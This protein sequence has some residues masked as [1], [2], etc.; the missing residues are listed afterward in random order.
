MRIEALAGRVFLAL[1]AVV[2]T[3]VLIEVASRRLVPT[4]PG[5][6]QSLDLGTPREPK[7]YV[8]F[9]TDENGPYVNRLGYP[10]PVPALPKPAGEYRIFML[11]GS[12]VFAGNPPLAVQIERELRT[13]GLDA[14]RVYNFGVVSSV[15]GMELARIVFE[16]GGYE[17]DLVLLYDGGNDVVVPFLWDPRPGY[18]FNFLLYESNPLMQDADR[19]PTALLLG[20]GSNLL[21]RTFR[22]FFTER[23][24]G[25]GRLRAEA[26]WQTEPWRDA[27][28][29]TYVD[30]LVKGARASRGFG[31]KFMGFLQPLL[32][33]KATL[34]E[35]EVT[36]RDVLDHEHPGLREHCV[37]MRPKMQAAMRAAP[38]DVRDDFVDMSGVYDAVPGRT[39]VDFIHPIQETTP[40]LVHVIARAILDR[41]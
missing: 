20:F 19:Y 9:G 23:L 10:G 5:L 1:V 17:P 13:S 35:H 41:R 3:L 39:F 12:T 22:D 2:A 38:A 36:V 30:H 34:E 11:G 26:G 8:V 16:V 18:P 33:W 25:L 28:A 24:L 14:A 15:S 40:V 32:Y 27:I 4:A 21:R 29:R 7:P 6:A 31:A 37:A